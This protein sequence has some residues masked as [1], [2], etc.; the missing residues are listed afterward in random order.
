MLEDYSGYGKRRQ[1]GGP[2]FVFLMALCLGPSSLRNLTPLIKLLMKSRKLYNIWWVECLEFGITFNYTNDCY[3]YFFTVNTY[4]IYTTSTPNLNKIFIF[5]ITNFQ[6][7]VG[8][9]CHRLTC[10]HC[11]CTKDKS[12]TD[13]PAHYLHSRERLQ[14]SI[15]FPGED[16]GSAL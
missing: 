7:L 9:M 3:L 12:S 16:V 1:Q 2:T 15:F 6:L 11:F 8:W 10:Y 14:L 5:S 4:L 13:L